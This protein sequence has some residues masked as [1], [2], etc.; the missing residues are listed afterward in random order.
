M[1]TREHIL[2]IAEQLFNI[3]GYTAVGVDLIAAQARVSKTSLYRLFGSKHQLI[4]AV[5]GRRHQR[6]AAAMMQAVEVAQTPGTKVVALL[7]WHFEWFAQPGFYGCM[8]MHA[9]AEF[10]QSDSGLTAQA[11]AHKVW[12]NL[13]LRDLVQQSA[14]QGAA[15]SAI[16]GKAAMLLTLLEGMII[17]AE[18]GMLAAEAHYLAMAEWILNPVAASAA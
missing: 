11:K 15:Q 18:F 17:S 7:R 3:Q 1:Q 6:F 10:K 16:A 12:L 14:Q 2:D 9:V 4:S 8:F 13:L 5:L